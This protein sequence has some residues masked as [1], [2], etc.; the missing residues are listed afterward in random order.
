M[1]TYMILL[2]IGI[3]YAVNC[4]TAD[5]VFPDTDATYTVGFSLDVD[6]HG[7]RN[8][9]NIALKNNS[10]YITFNGKNENAY[11]TE[12]IPW[13]SY[14]LVLYQGFSVSSNSLRVFWLYCSADAD[15]I[16]DLYVEDTNGMP[17][18]HVSVSGSCIMNNMSTEV[19][20]RIPRYSTPFP[21][22]VKKFVV[23]GPNITIQPG[24]IGS[25][26]ISQVP[27]HLPENYLLLVFQYVDCSSCVAANRGWY[28]MHTVFWDLTQT[29]LCF[30]IG[31]LWTGSDLL[32]WSHAFCL[33]NLNFPPT[34]VQ[35]VKWSL[36]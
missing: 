3:C 30:G 25:M 33:P 9:K 19:S 34:F 18:Q 11:I 32:Q 26:N 22:P 10:G 14:H 24:E 36:K 4:I 8:I 16:H 15:K 23:S 12:Q 35:D 31:Y 5:L 1:A 20:V 13:S 27:D 2:L 28:E 29:V 6:G 17:W 7:S 21:S